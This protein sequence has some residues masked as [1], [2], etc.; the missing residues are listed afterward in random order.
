MTPTEASDHFAAW[1]P[2]ELH[3][4]LPEKEWES[5]AKDI[6]EGRESSLSPEFLK[7][8]QSAGVEYMEFR[9]RKIVPHS[10]V[11][12]VVTPKGQ[13]EKIKKPLVK[14]DWWE[15]KTDKEK[16]Q[17]CN[18]HPASHYC[19]KAAGVILELVASENIA[20]RF[21][22][23][24]NREAF[25]GHDALDDGGID[26]ALKVAGWEMKR[27]GYNFRVFFHEDLGQLEIRITADGQSDQL[28]WF[29]KLEDEALGSGWVARSGDAVPEIAEIAKG[30]R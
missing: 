26:K 12:K 29:V 22:D 14:K 2:L 19:P 27:A 24:I 17:Y 1:A 7:K 9:A 28:R 8:L 18:D 13:D 30:L 21:M 25:L 23:K 20:R 10:F 11:K 5:I 15:E 3:G 4:V 6:R 16:K